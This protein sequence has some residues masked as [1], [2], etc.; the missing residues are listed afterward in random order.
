MP[1]VVASRATFAFRRLASDLR[2]VR[3]TVTPLTGK[4]D[5]L[6]VCRA[7]AVLSKGGRVYATAEGPSPRHAIDAA[8]ERLHALTRRQLTVGE[9][10]RRPS[11]LKPRDTASYP[12]FG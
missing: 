6:A 7:T 1:S 10:K 8:L 4:S 9:F 3:V 5:K 12:A 2:R 11:V